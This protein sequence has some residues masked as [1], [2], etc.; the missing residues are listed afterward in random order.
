VFILQMLFYAAAAIG[1]RLPKTNRL[2]KILYLPTFLVQSN[3]AALIG[4]YRF[5]TGQ[6]STLWQRAPRRLQ[7]SE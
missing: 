3:G 6:Q 2:G 4:L 7:Q 1:S 5:L